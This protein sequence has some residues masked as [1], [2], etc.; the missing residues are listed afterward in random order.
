M[1]EAHATTVKDLQQLSNNV[2][3]RWWQDAGL[4]RLNSYILVIW[5]S[6]IVGGY[7]I[8]LMGSLVALPRFLSGKSILD[9]KV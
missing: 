3:K 2:G 8:A 1:A 9:L 5:L 7:D 6:Q 4:R